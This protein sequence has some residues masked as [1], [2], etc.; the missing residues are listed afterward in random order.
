MSAEVH[1]LISRIHDCSQ[2]SA[3]QHLHL[4]LLILESERTGHAA[5]KGSQSLRPV[6][7]DRPSC[8]GPSHGPAGGALLVTSPAYLVVEDVYLVGVLYLLFGL[9]ALFA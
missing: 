6:A 3:W 1:S 8:L 5:R 2:P 7:V 9:V 4:R